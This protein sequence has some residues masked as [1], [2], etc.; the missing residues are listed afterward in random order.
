M[1]T[2]RNIYESN[3]FKKI[4]K[5]EVFSTKNIGVLR[6]NQSFGEQPKE[7]NNII[8]KSAK[9][10]LGIYTNFK[11]RPLMSSTQKLSCTPALKYSACIAV[12]EIVS[13]RS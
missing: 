11:S 4:N 12:I 7:L 6:V 13:M 8:G 2:Q 5:G 3:S 10:D 9:N 1:K